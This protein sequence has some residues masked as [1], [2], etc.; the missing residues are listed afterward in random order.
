MVMRMRLP[1]RSRQKG[2]AAAVAAAAAAATGRASGGRLHDGSR[3]IAVV[4]VVVQVLVVSGGG[5]VARAGSRRVVVVTRRFVAGH[6]ALQHNGRALGA[7][8]IVA[9]VVPKPV[10]RWFAAERQKPREPVP[11]DSKH[12]LKVLFA[13]QIIRIVEDLRS[14][15][16][17]KQNT[18]F[19]PLTS[20]ASQRHTETSG[21]THTHLSTRFGVAHHSSV[22]VQFDGG[23]IG[24]DQVQMQSRHSADR[25]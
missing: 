6:N 19:A 16:T 1:R 3:C 9:R 13:T 14:Q 17:N 25:E 15:Q 2:D 18:P 8:L 12:R 20:H 5:A 4:R 11:A 23:L 21:G 10:A 24:A 7:G 22:V